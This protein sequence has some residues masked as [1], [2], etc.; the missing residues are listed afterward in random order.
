MLAA[1]MM[2]TMPSRG[3]TPGQH[4]TRR[5]DLVQAGSH[6]RKA[7]G[8]QNNACGRGACQRRH[9]Q[10]Q[11]PIQVREK[12]PGEGRDGKGRHR[13]DEKRVD[14][15]V[16]HEHAGKLAEPDACRFEPDAAN[17]V[18]SDGAGKK[19]GEEITDEGRADRLAGGY[20]PVRNKRVEP[21]SAP[22]L[23]RGENQHRCT[24]NP[25]IEGKGCI[26]GPPVDFRDKPADQRQRDDDLQDH[27]RPR[28][29]GPP[30]PGRLFSHG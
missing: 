6:R 26:Q 15:A 5:D 12:R 4:Q 19:I 27:Q 17:N 14:H 21:Q 11:S 25:G 7:A 18:A 9:D 28:A 23:G 1:V 10:K 29:A 13:R 22:N 8:C 20:L 3:R 2:M 16:K 30:P 24:G